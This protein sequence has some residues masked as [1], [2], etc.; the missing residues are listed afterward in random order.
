MKL[1]RE[2]ENKLKSFTKTRVEKFFPLWI[3]LDYTK[4]TSTF[5]KIRCLMPYKADHCFKCDRGFKA[6]ETIALVGLKYVG[7]KVFCQKCARE[8]Q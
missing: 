5:E 4:Y 7:N 8:L 1:D 2:P 6:N 3:R